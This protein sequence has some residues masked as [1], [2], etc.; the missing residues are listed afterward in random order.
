MR[1]PD[2][3]VSSA[4]NAMLTMQKHSDPKTVMRYEH[5]RENREQKAVNFLRYEDGGMNPPPFLSAAI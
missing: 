4:R 5:V 2:G 1:T 3:A